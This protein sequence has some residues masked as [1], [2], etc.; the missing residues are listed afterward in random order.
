MVLIQIQVT[1]NVKC[2]NVKNQSINEQENAIFERCVKSILF[3][4]KK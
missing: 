2:Q 3:L 1:G 4:L